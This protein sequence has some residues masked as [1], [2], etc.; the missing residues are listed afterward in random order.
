MVG[1]DG[2]FIDVF[3]LL[4][5]KFNYALLFLDYFQI[6]MIKPKIF[7]SLVIIFIKKLP[8]S[9]AVERSLEYY[10]AYKFTYSLRSLRSLRTKTRLFHKLSSDISLCFRGKYSKSRN[11]YLVEMGYY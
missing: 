1:L 2:L 7:F 6:F 9:S 5:F 4:K 3:L 10:L 11:I 8:I